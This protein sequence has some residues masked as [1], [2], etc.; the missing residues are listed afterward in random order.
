MIGGSFFNPQPKASLHYSNLSTPY[1]VETKEGSSR[2]VI[3]EDGRFHLFSSGPLTN[4][5]S[6]NG[7]ILVSED[8]ACV[9]NERCAHC[10]E[11]RRTELVQIATGQVFG[12][13][14]EVKPFDE[15]TPE[16]ITTL[17]VIGCRAWHFN[18]SY[19]FVSPMVMEFIK[20][21]GITGLS[22]SLGFSRFVGS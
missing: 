20:K 6:G 17:Q 12:I 14:Y 10:I 16:S 9:L 4:L 5:F 2:C 19:L 11:L 8:F 18:S 15:I 22:F 7:N 3:L 13:Y 21:Q 1:N